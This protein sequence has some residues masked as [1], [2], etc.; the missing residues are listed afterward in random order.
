MAVD[1]AVAGEQFAAFDDVAGGRQSLR[2][3]ALE[4][5]DL[6]VT[7]GATRRDVARLK[8]GPFP[9][10][11]DRVE[12]RQRQPRLLPVVFLLPLLFFFG[13][14]RR[15]GGEDKIGVQSAHTA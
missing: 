10:L 9:E 14:F 12:G 7:L 15:V 11:L 13:G 2:A 6:L 8:H 5:E 3:M 4:I 1:A